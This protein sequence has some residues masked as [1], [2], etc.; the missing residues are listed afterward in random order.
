VIEKKKEETF[1]CLVSSISSQSWIPSS[2]PI[3]ILKLDY[4]EISR[5]SE[6][7]DTSATRSL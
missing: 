5:D 2:T 1:G 3:E 6:G 4:S 7:K